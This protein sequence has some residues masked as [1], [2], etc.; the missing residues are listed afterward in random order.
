M[1][2]KQSANA[3]RYGKRYDDSVF[4][5]QLKD[6]LKT[7]P[8]GRRELDDFLHFSGMESSRVAGFRRGTQSLGECIDTV[9]REYHKS[10]IGLEN[11]RK[12]LKSYDKSNRVSEAGMN[13]A[14]ILT[15]YRRK[16]IFHALLDTSEIDLDRGKANDLLSENLAMKESEETERKKAQLLLE[17]DVSPRDEVDKLIHSQAFISPK[18]KQIL[19]KDYSLKKSA[20]RALAPS[21]SASSPSPSSPLYPAQSFYPK[22]NDYN[23][24]KDRWGNIQRDLRK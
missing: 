20:T 8:N 6:G 11:T 23:V 17:S 19:N 15:E 18:S 3:S 12:I 16:L 1:N 22:W 2:L 5:K 13:P 7:D 4:L 9:E 10:G 14:T 24:M 21:H